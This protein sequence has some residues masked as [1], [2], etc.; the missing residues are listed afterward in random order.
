M[1]CK[2]LIH[3]QLTFSTARAIIILDYFFILTCC[4]ELPN[5]GLSVIIAIPY[6]FIIH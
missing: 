1:F 4:F 2:T 5:L 3:N 6:Y